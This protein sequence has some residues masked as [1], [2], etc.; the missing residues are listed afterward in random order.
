MSLSD[1]SDINGKVIIPGVDDV[2]NSGRTPLYAMKPFLEHHPKRS[3][4]RY[5]WSVP[6]RC[7]GAAGLCGLSLSTTIQEHITVVISRA[8]E[9]GIYLS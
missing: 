3:R 2:S 8:G 1:D 9:E 5:W 7:F 4:W 6:I